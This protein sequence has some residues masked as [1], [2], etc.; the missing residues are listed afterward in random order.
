[1]RFR[2]VISVFVID[3]LSK[4]VSRF[5]SNGF[6]FKG[7]GICSYES[8]GYLI[9]LFFFIPYKRWLAFLLFAFMLFIIQLF[10]RFYW[11]KYR[12]NRLIYTAF[13][14]IIAG[15]LGNFFDCMVF[16]YV[17]DIFIVP[18]IRSTN[19][20]DIF[21]LVGLGLMLIEFWINSS[22]RRILFK[23]RPLK[24]EFALVSP[25]FDI[26]VQDIKRLQKFCL[27]IGKM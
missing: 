9:G 10:F 8:Q 12:R 15:F 19:I 14:F 27:G 16:K 11:M 24:E 25:M 6:Q 1:M 23:L 20:A 3:Q 26:V 22:F 21:I 17:R 5:W 4:L 18:F 7:F 2:L 13:S